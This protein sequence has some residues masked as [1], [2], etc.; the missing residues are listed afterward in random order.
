MKFSPKLLA[1][2]IFLFLVIPLAALF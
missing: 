1:F 2:P